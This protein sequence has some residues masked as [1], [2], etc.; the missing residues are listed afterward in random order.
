MLRK[1]RPTFMRED[2]FQEAGQILRRDVHNLNTCLEAVDA[3]EQYRLE[4]PPEL[5][6]GALGHLTLG[7][8]TVTSVA[9][10][11]T[12]LISDTSEI[13]QGRLPARNLRPARILR[14]A[15][16]LRRPKRIKGLKPATKFTTNRKIALK[17]GPGN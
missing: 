10:T 6:L 1:R 3:F 17:R 14:P 13:L 16:T 4:N 2:F 11:G 9:L 12:V 15:R 8:L 7:L 5:F